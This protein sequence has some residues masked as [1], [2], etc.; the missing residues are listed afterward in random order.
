MATEPEI[1]QANFYGIPEPLLARVIEM[2]M[3]PS[4]EVIEIVSALQ[5]LPRV[6]AVPTH[7]QPIGFGTPEDQSGE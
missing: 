3:R 1:P 6:Q 4:G 5:H 7:E 2:L